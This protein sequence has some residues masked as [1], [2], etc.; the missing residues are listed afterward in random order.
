MRWAK[1]GRKGRKEERKK[2]KKEKGP[3]QKGA[4]LRNTARAGI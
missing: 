3:D 2:L 1:K 4:E